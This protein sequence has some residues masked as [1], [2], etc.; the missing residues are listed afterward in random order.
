MSL[1]DFLFPRAEL[2]LTVVRSFKSDIEAAKGIPSQGYVTETAI[3][4]LNN[5]DLRRLGMKEGSNVSLK[6][7]S[8]EV[9]VKAAIGE[10]TPEGSAAMPFGPWALA[11]VA[12]P[13]DESPPILHGIAV[14]TTRSDEDVTPIESL[15]GP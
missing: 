1:G 6:S 3:V 13:G 12:I 15:L 9:V 8:G 2:K 14:T 7:P 4:R 11:L 5:N 10:K